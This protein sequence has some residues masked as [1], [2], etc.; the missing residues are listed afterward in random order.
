VR[1][2]RGDEVLDRMDDASC[3]ATGDCHGQDV[4]GT[5]PGVSLS[6]SRHLPPRVASSPLQGIGV[7]RAL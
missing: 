1:D 3:N 6:G 7:A 4:E 5:W 2:P